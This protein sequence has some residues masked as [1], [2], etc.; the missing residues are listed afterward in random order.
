[1]KQQIQ[2]LLSMVA[3][4]QNASMNRDATEE[5]DDIEYF[6]DEESNRYYYIDGDGETQ[7]KETASD[8]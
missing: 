1:M 3:A 2:L 6:H 8:A 5:D 7:W 4:S